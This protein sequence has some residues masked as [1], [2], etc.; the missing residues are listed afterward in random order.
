LTAG[1]V[2]SL[3]PS[4]R[5]VWEQARRIISS[6]YPPIGV[7]DW[8][9]SRADLEQTLYVEALTNARLRQELGQISLVAR[10]DIVFGPGTT[11]IMAAFTHPNVSGSRF[12]NG[13]YGVYYAARDEHTAIKEARH[14]SAM[15]ARYSGHPPTRFEMRMYI[16]R[17]AGVLHDIRGAGRRWQGVYDPSNYVAGQ[18][19]GLG[20]RNTQSFGLVYD[21]VRSKGGVC[22]AAFRPPVVKPVK[23]SKHFFFDWDGTNIARVLEVG[24][25][26]TH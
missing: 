14:S 18:L 16:G 3:P 9:K 7:F 5:I 26:V 10:A 25:V 24:E 21:S 17:I 19:L 22:V 6:R 1:A 4:L 2:K 15:F 12:S 8:I 23:Q 13:T 20:L 11:P